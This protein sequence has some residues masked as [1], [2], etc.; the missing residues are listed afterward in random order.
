MLTL[1]PHTLAGLRDRALLALG[2]AGA[3]RRSELVALEFAGFSGPLDLLLSLARTRQMNAERH[4]TRY[5]YLWTGP[6]K[7]LHSEKI[8]TIRSSLT[9]S[10]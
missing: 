9:V 6:Y 7:Y 5:K 8:G 10:S 2:F 4:P 3:F 1:C